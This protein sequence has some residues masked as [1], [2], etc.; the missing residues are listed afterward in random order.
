MNLSRSLSLALLSLLSLCLALVQSA[1]TTLQSVHSRAF[2]VFDDPKQFPFMKSYSE[3][4]ISD[5]QG[6]SADEEAT[7]IFVRPFENI[8]LA[9]VPYEVFDK[10]KLAIEAAEDAEI[11]LFGPAIADAGEDTLT[12]QALKVG[13]TKNRVLFA[14]ATLQGLLIEAAHNKVMNV[15][16]PYEEEDLR[17]CPVAVPE[18]F[19]HSR[20]RS[21]MERDERALRSKT[22]PESPH[23]QIRG[24]LKEVGSPPC[25]PV[26]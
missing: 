12:G 10:M 4:Q 18:R 1:P 21:R 13:M 16:D 7:E 9:S 6:G 17:S 26:D 8:S 3:F 19:W 2:Y 20:T 25:C 14:T 24:D 23:T 5:G 15:V 11:E 22:R